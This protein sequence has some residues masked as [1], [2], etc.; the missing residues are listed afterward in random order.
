MPESGE[1]ILRT[2]TVADVRQLERMHA[3]FED[4]PDTWC[5]VRGC[6]Q[7]RE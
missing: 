4:I 6:S 1:S 7:K 2:L 5:H 3:Y